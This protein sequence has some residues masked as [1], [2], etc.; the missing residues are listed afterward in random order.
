MGFELFFVG[1]FFCDFLEC[2]LKRFSA[3]KDLR[4]LLFFL[5]P[6]ILRSFFF[7]YRY[8]F[9]LFSRNRVFY[10]EKKIKF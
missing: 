4:F 1:N 10:I 9:N 6:A 3:I 8:F 5:M 2:F 7:F